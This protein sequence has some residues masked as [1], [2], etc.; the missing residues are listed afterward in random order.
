MADDKALSAVLL[1]VGATCSGKTEVSLHIAERLKGEIISADSR[2]IYKGFRIG[3]AQP[4]ADERKRVRHHLVDF[5]DPTERYSAGRFMSDAREALSSITARGMKPIVVGGTGLYIEA[6]VSGIFQEPARDEA[7]RAALRKR[8]ESEGLSF[9]HEELGRV[10]P[11]SARRI[12]VNDAKRITRALEIYYLTG[13]KLSELQ[14]LRKPVVESSILIFLNRQ[15][16]DLQRRIR[17]RVMGMISSGLVD[18]VRGL[19]DAGVPADAPAFESLGYGAAVDHL[20]GRISL[21]EMTERIEKETRN[22]AKRQL[23]WFKKMKD[24][25]PVE[26]KEGEPPG[27]ISSRIMDILAR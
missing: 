14:I 4:D 17:E 23:T 15:K 11:D 26:V 22:L 1:I 7:L 13:R 10:D 2:Q 20:Q 16:D 9:L 8:A 3:T 21:S 5:L 27:A 24:L 19:L 12:H 25:T 18:E 6:L